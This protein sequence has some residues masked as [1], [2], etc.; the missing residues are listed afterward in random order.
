MKTIKRVL[1][2]AKNVIILIAT[3]DKALIAID[4]SNLY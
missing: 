1:R 3:N 4:K 2:I